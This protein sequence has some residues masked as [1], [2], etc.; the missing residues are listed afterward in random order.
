MRVFLDANVLFSASNGGSNNIARL[1]ALLTER[2]IGVTSDVAVEEARR[3]LA[4]KRQAW[5]PA[6]EFLL[7]DL[8]IVPSAL[9]D[10]PVSLDTTDASLLCAA[11]RSR[12][13]YFVTGDR[14]D[15]GH[16]Y[17]QTVHGVEIISLLHLADVLSA[18]S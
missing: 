4:L 9:F 14:R 1:I 16:L 5:R 6:L 10:L 2:E 3:N 17:G 13:V 7:K 18:G 11:I 15:F 12:C 8:E